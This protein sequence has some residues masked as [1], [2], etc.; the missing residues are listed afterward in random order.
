MPSDAHRVFH[1]V[2]AVMTAALTL[3]HTAAAAEK[4]HVQTP[5]GLDKDVAINEKV[6]AECAVED[7]VAYFVRE[8]AKDSFEVV[9]TKTL[10]ASG[11]KTLSLTIL[12]VQGVGG[13]A[14]SGAKAITL[15]GSLKDGGKEIGSF[16]ARRS[17]GGGAFGGY[18]GT[19]SILERCAK[20][21]GKDISQWLASPTMN[22]GLGEIKK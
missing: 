1:T 22:A 4:L 11:G 20:A 3:V 9:A 21:L 2:L 12:Q 16:T 14:W 7:R 8:H 5:A 18:K 19:C 6:K 15:Q 13:G 10:P 17:S